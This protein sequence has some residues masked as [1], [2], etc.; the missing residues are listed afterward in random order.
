[1]SRKNRKNRGGGKGGGFVKTL[2]PPPEGKGKGRSRKGGADA[3]VIKKP[4]PYI[5]PDPKA[6]I[7]PEGQI[8]T[9]KLGLGAWPLT[10]KVY[11]RLADAIREKAYD[12]RSWVRV[13]VGDEGSEDHEH[14]AIHLE[15]IADEI[16]R[17]IKQAA[18]E[19]GA[20][21]A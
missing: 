7:L 3:V 2:S 10:Q 13:A 12:I 5:I 8:L 21:K 11:A 9:M 20:V 4:L 15:R 18:E 19:I 14:D 1:M 16:D 17:A 6:V